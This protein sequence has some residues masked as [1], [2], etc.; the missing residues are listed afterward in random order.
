MCR[1]LF[2]DVFE[3]FFVGGNALEPAERRDIESSRWSSACSGTGDCM[4]ILD[5]CGIEAGGEKIGGDF[6]GVLRD[7]RG[8]G[9]VRGQRVP[10][11][12]EVKAF[13]L[14]IVL[15]LDPVFERAEVVADVEA[16][17]GAHAA[18]DSFRSSCHELCSPWHGG[19]RQCG[20]NEKG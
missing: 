17:G 16:A 14:R 11:G 13:V 6:D 18:Q 7:W 9:V 1:S 2:C 8:V 19:M 4:K 3:G 12:D 15:E 10:V 20:P 5:F